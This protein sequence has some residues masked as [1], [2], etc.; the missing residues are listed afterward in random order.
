MTW[1]LGKLCKNGTLHWF[2]KADPAWLWE[3]YKDPPCPTRAAPLPAA[4]AQLC[5]P[6]GC[7][8]QGQAARWNS[9][10][11][12]EWMEKLKLVKVCLVLLLVHQNH[13]QPPHC[14]EWNLMVVKGTE[15]SWK[16][17]SGFFS[18]LQ[19]WAHFL[20]HHLGV[21]GNVEQGKNTRFNCWSTSILIIACERLLAWCSVEDPTTLCCNTIPLNVFRSSRLRTWI[22]ERYLLLPIIFHFCY[23]LT[24][25]RPT[26]LVTFVACS[27]SVRPLNS[28]NSSPMSLA[29]IT[30]QRLTITDNDRFPFL[31]IN[32]KPSHFSFL[33]TRIARLPSLSV[34]RLQAT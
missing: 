10:S 25:R 32:F 31:T 13:F 24:C 2:W 8:R 23:T 27:P 14:Q 19:S 20:V 29:S 22:Q 11:E 21:G 18:C 12:E 34:L 30:C 3:N 9:S 5:R 28:S 17:S 33:I 16:Q 4:W 7:W 15:K 1:I 6:P 26:F